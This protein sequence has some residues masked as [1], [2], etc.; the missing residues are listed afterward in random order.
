MASSRTK[1]PHL[2]GCMENLSPVATGKGMCFHRSAALMLDL[3][4]AELVMGTFRAAAGSGL[5]A[6]LKN[7]DRL[8]SDKTVG[9]I[10]LDAAG[11]PYELTANRTVVPRQ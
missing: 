1:Y 6:H 4:G 10:L 11:V 9:E 3:R 7:G 2:V 5:S 8:T